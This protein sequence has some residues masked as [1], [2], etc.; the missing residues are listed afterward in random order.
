M[1]LVQFAIGWTVLSIPAAIAVGAILRRHREADELDAD[2][3]RYL[4][5][6]CRPRSW[7]RSTHIAAELDV[8]PGDVIRAL[9]RLRAAG[10]AEVAPRRRVYQDPGMPGAVWRAT[11]A[12]TLD[13][14]N[15][16]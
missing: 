10:V 12:N 4:T 6:S 3:Y 5:R 7:Q 16:Q 9:T 8:N 1:T 11:V 15:D 14:E 13:H 2:I